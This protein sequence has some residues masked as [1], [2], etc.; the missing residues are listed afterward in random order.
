MNDLITICVLKKEDK[1]VEYIKYLVE[2][3]SKLNFDEIKVSPSEFLLKL[4]ELVTSNANINKINDIC[5]NRVM[6]VSLIQAHKIKLTELTKKLLIYEEN[7]VEK[8]LP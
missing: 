2:H 1:N 7:Q 8:L 3:Y 5:A 6:E 4:H